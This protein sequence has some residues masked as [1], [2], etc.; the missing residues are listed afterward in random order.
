MTFRTFAT[1]TISLATALFAQTET[2]QFVPFKD[3]LASTK[4]PNSLCFN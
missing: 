2:A 3:F 4:A 1:I